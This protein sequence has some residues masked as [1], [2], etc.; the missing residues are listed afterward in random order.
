MITLTYERIITETPDAWLIEFE[1]DGLDSVQAWLPKSQCEID[2]PCD[3]IDVP[4]WL[5]AQEELDKY[6]V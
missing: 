6:A 4:E 1:L 5:V 2:K 3:L